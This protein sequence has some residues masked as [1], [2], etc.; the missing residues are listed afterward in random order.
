MTGTQANTG[1]WFEPET[2]YAKI[3]GKDV[4]PRDNE[5]KSTIYPFNKVTETESGHVVEFDDTPGA[6]RVQIFHRSGTF[7]EI[8]PN[9]DKVEKI[10]RDRY[11]SILRDSNVHI[12]G[13][14]NVT[15][16]KGLKIFVNRD[17]LPNTEASCVNFDVHVGRN[18]NVNLFME[19]GNCNVRMNDGDINLQMMK[20]DVNFRQE[21][22]NF[23][24]FINGD[25]NLEC[26]G[27]MHT[28]VGSDQVTEV[29]GSRDTRVDGLFDNL[30]VTTGYKETKVDLGDHRLEV[31]GNVYDL[32]HQ[33]HQTRILLNRIIEIIGNND[34]VIGANDT[35]NVRAN[36]NQTVTGSRFATTVGSVNT[37]TLGSTKETTAGSLDIRA[38]AKAAI[39]SS[40][41]HLN[42][43]A[44][45]LGTAG[46][47]H[48]NGPVASPAQSAAAATPSGVRPVYIPGPPGVW[49]PSIPTHPKSPLSQ[50]KNITTDLA[51][52]LV[53]V[54]TLS[55]MNF[56]ISQQLGVLTENTAAITQSISGQVDAVGSAVSQ[57]ISGALGAAQGATS[58]L[59]D[60]ASGAAGI[61]SSAVGS[62]TGA[63]S[64]TTDAIGGTAALGSTVSGA[65]A[66]VI[67]GATSTIQNGASSLGGLGDA[68]TGIGSVLGDVI[69]AIVEIGCAVGDFI[70]GLISSVLNPVMSAINSVFAK[71]SEILG[72]VTNFIGGILNKIGEVI[73]G[74]LGAVND[75]IGKIMD[76]AGKFIG[77]IA[78]AINGLLSNLFDGVGDL[79]CG[80]DLL[81][82][83]VPD[84]GVG[85]LPSVPGV[86]GV[87]P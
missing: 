43:G 63:L 41:M 29:G 19:K 4:P 73:G 74:I 65:T 37:S 21:R 55:Q 9:G 84:I 59:S 7:E 20:G 61:A 10:V 39:S 25:Y 13:F 67:G 33:T 23:N 75:I 51:G 53:A 8:H 11:V 1:Q 2:P 26:T 79:G 66:G 34:E 83:N 82:G 16:D 35:L 6:E 36:Q 64:A 87:L 28:V 80:K 30:Q 81:A 50:L 72:T 69:G 52:Q 32:F 86:G 57:N 18:A 49:I 15:V 14:S 45:I 42:G 22:G 44:S 17:N 24:H 54:N 85:A 58:Q 70:N 12:D 31:G 48:L 40:I 47:I 46:T 3:K 27:H 77:G 68:F 38:G 5:S 62:A 76:G 71:I 78:A 56:G 60:M